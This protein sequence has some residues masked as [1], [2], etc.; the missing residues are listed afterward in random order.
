MKMVR[1]GEWKTYYE[2]GK[3]LNKG[4]YKLGLEDGVGSHGMKM[5]KQKDRVTF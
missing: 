4:D 1:E 5:G 2:S 3:T